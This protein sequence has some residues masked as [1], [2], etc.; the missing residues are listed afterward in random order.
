[1]AMKLMYI[2]NQPAVAGIAEKAGVD[3][4]FIDMEWIGKDKRQGGLDTV[5]NH[6]TIGDI[7]KIKNVLKQA[8]LMVRINP[9][10]EAAGEYGSS[11]EEIDA[12]IDAG[13]DILMLPYFTTVRE[14]EEFLD[15]V[16]GRVKTLPL[17]ESKAATE[18][19]EEILSLKGLEEVFI[20]LNDLSLDYGKKFMFELL[21]DGTVE[22][23]CLACKHRGISYGFGGIAAIG[24][25]LL[26]AEHI[27]REHYRMG[28]SCTIL[29]RSFCDVEKVSS[30]QELEQIFTQ[31]VRE[32]REVEAECIKYAGYFQDNERIVAEKVQKICEAR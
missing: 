5:Q 14:V 2:T 3:R 16:A 26:P 6:H 17:I 20:G 25:G 30:E 18:K 32:I 13:A 23:L 8:E 22:R 9:I 1:M 15:I 27:I 29:S 28:S 12:A 31:G 11:K 10:H 24:K 19:I 21:T 7:K 4:I